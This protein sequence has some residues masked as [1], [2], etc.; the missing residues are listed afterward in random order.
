MT[1]LDYSRRL[2]V[3]WW[4]R[5]SHFKPIAGTGHKRIERWHQENA[6]QQSRE[7]TADDD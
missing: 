7:Q 2:Q 6:N 4:D 1:V 5:A 3:D